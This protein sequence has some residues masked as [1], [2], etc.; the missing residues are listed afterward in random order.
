MDNHVHNHLSCSITS[1]C[2]CKQDFSFRT[3]VVYHNPNTKTILEFIIMVVN[4]PDCTAAWFEN[5]FPNTIQ[6]SAVI[7]L[8]RLEMFL[9][10][11][12]SVRVIPCERTH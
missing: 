7:S 1:L 8:L 5:V 4:V 11:L 2:L 3:T 6:M 12:F 9:Q 10:R